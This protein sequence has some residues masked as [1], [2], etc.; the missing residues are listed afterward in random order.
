VQAVLGPGL[1]GLADHVFVLLTG[2][3][4]S[5]TEANLAITFCLG[6][7]PD[8]GMVGRIGCDARGRA[9]AGRRGHRS[10]GGTGHRAGTDLLIGVFGIQAAVH[11]PAQR[12]ELLQVERASPILNSC[13][14]PAVW[15]P[16]GKA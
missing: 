1:F 14:P 8:G 7:G 5:S 3:A 6:P 4:L 16:V 2:Y 11:R 10:G 9:A 15:D 12:P 13:H